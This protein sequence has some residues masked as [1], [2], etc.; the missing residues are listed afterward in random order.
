MK[1][2]AWWTARSAGPG[3]TCSTGWPRRPGRWG[4][5]SGSAT[6]MA[7]TGY[8]PRCRPRLSLVKHP[9]PRRARRK[10][11]WPNGKR[12]CVTSCACWTR[13]RR[14]GRPPSPDRK[15]WKLMTSSSQ[16]GSGSP[17]SADG[18]SASVRS[19]PEASE[20]RFQSILFEQPA[21]RRWRRRAA[22]A[23]LLRRL[24]SRP[25]AGVDDRRPEAVRPEAVL[26]R[27][28]ARRGGR[29]LPARGAA[30]PRAARCARVGHEVRGD[31]AA[32]ARAPRGGGE[33]P[34]PAPEAGL[35]PGRRRDLLPGGL[36]ARG[37]ARRA[38]C[39][40]ARLSR[41]PRLPRRVR[42]LRALH[43]ACRAD[44]GAEGG[45]GRGAVRDPDPREPGS[46]SATTK[47]SPTTAPRW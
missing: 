13:P 17:F 24:E 16:D 2:P 12:R 45:A 19:R 39:D 30:R 33:A 11:N 9:Q 7:P 4:G 15:R 8:G 42:R 1:P 41:A 36:L 25:G 34:L 18:A 6:P 3:G 44:A 29:P 46:R 26:L 35:V 5:W 40:L 43:L 38:R 27:T 23:G 10:K 22:G 21:S 28:A 31:D 37:R 20:A 32:D 47:A 14:R